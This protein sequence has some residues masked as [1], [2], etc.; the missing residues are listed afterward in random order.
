MQVEK[1]ISS[2]EPFI[3]DINQEGGEEGGPVGMGREVVKKKTA[4]TEK[5]KIRRSWVQGK[6]ST[7][8]HVLYAWL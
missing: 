8:L 7:W 4:S 1:N 6:I 5:T 3:I 2:K